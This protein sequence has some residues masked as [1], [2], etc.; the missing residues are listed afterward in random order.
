M[1]ARARAKKPHPPLSQPSPPHP[2]RTPD[3]HTHTL[4]LPRHRLTSACPPRHPSRPNHPQS[5]RTRGLQ[6]NSTRPYPPVRTDRQT[7][8]RQQPLFRRHNPF[9][10]PHSGNPH[11]FLPQHRRR[12]ETG[13]ARHCTAAAMPS[14]NTATPKHQKSPCSGKPL[15]ARRSP[16]PP[17]LPAHHP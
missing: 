8:A 13:T 12:P 2:Q 11:P 6:K 7:P 1:A 5:L 15:P 14:E 9:R 16:A 10:H 17:P 4:N 3:R